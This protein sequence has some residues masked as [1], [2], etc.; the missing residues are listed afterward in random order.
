MDD[1]LLSLSERR[2]IRSSA[3]TSDS[4]TSKLHPDL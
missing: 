3:L 1:S 4:L 2:E